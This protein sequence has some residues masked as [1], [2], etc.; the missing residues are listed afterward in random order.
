MIVVGRAFERGN[1][2]PSLIFSF[3]WA[4]LVYCPVARWT[5]SSH[6]WL[7]NLSALDFAGGGPVHIASGWAALAYA[8]VLG[9]RKDHGMVSLRKPHNTTL[10][11]IGTVLIC[12][13]WLG[14]NVRSLSTIVCLEGC[15]AN[16]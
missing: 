2:L 1:I 15:A 5:W 11:F 13:G 4:T 3:F 14:F 12:F 6:G 9:K 8:M 10:V 7:Y 16:Q